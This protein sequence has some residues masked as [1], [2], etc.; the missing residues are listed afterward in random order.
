MPT[1]QEALRNFLRVERSAYTN[2]NYQIHIG[3]LVNAL[4]PERDVALVTHDELADQV[5][6]LRSQSRPLTIATIS[7]YVRFWGTFFNWCVEEE[8][9]DRSPTR[10]LYIK[11]PGREPGNRA[12]P[13]ATLADMVNAARRSPRNYAI[14]LFMIDTGCRVGGLES[15]KRSRLNL[16]ERTAVLFEKGSKWH[17]VYFSEQTAEALGAWL[18][19]RPKAKHDYVFTAKGK[20]APPLRRGAITNVV[21]SAARAVNSEKIW[22]GH[23]IRHAVGHAYASADVPKWVTQKKLGHASERSTDHY[24]PDGSERVKAAAQLLPLA[25]LGN[26]LTEKGKIIAFPGRT[27]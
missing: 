2:R 12:I 6:R 11:N 18:D 22:T 23:A 3:R 4:G 24:Y 16:E 19:M 7:T 26:T 9:L 27:A 15:L 5:D 1:L 25:P 10:R 14:L 17:T 8:Y 21:R 13:G 20:D